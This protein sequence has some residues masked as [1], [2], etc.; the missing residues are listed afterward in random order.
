[1][2]G[3]KGDAGAQGPAGSAV[4]GSLLLM[5]EDVAPPAGYRM[6][7]SYV[8]ERI[9]RDGAGRGRKFNMRI[10]IWQKL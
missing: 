6:I 10:V 9:D 3:V 1:M 8:E 2:N 4:T 5:P 7:G